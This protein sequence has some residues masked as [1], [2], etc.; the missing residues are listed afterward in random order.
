MNISSKFKCQ[1]TFNWHL[2]LIEVCATQSWPVNIYKDFDV[3]HSS[4]D[5][6]ILP[7][8]S[9][10]IWRYQRRYQR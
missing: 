5:Y 3:C 10:K 7:M 9:K 6:S 1:L 4:T 8:A 2:N